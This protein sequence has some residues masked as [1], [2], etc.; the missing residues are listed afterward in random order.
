SMRFVADL[1][2]WDNTRQGIPLGES[3]DPKS[4]HWSDQLQDWQ[5]VTPA[6]FP[7]SLKAMAESLNEEVLLKPLD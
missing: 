6:L 4:A 3:G 5:N 7:F 2:N 1:R